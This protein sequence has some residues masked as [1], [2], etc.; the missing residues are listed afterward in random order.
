MG[1]LSNIFS[2]IGNFVKSEIAKLAGDATVVE[3]AIESAANIAD[4]LVNS[5]KNWV[6]TPA[7][8]AIESVIE[9]VPGI[10]PYVADILN[11]L[12]QLVTDLG[13]AVQEFTKSP[14]QVVQ[15]G[16]TA[17]INAPN[18]NIKATNLAVLNAHI[19]TKIGQLSQAPVTIQTA[20]S[21][22]PTV[23]VVNQGN[24]NLIPNASAVS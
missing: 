13:W 3:S 5:L 22:A 7:G 17:A 19:V 10:G 18:A 6:A 4:S 2:A 20:L 1:F 24:G 11:F 16:I 8:Q 9:A 21:M 14:A 23:H 12:P 15:D